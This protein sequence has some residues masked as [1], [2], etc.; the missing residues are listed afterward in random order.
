MKRKL[1][2]ALL[3]CMFLFITAF[4]PATGAYVGTWYQEGE[5]EPSFIFNEDGTCTL[6]GGLEGEWR[7]VNRKYLTI[8]AEDGETYAY[9]IKSLSGSELVLAGE[10][11]KL[12]LTG[13]AVEEKEPEKEEK[14]ES[15]TKAST[16]E[17]KKASLKAALKEAA[18]KAEEE[19]KE[20]EK[21]DSKEETVKEEVKPEE[22]VKEEEPEKEPEAIEEPETEPEIP[23]DPRVRASSTLKEYYAS[24]VLDKDPDTAW[25]EGADGDG[26]GEYLEFTVEDY[27][28]YGIIVLPGYMKNEEVYEENCVPEMLLIQ[29]GREKQ[30]IDI[31]DFEPD[32]DSK[33]PAVYKFEKP[34]YVNVDGKVKVSIVSVIEGTVSEHAGIS[35]L[36]LM[37]DRDEYLAY[38]PHARPDNGTGWIY[39]NSDSVYLNATEISHLSDEDLQLAINEMYARRGYKFRTPEIAAYFESLDWYEGTV[40]SADFDEK[41]F[42]EIEKYNLYLMKKERDKRG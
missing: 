32:F 19:E 27:E 38:T 10:G 42:S 11:E 20:P 2:A 24:N 15:S 6:L 31:S 28:V 18:S 22:T 30:L 3:A 39:K 36:H 40:N 25:F 4:T 5:K 14:T 21:A 23:E 35:E 12:T 26:S 34:L 8:K 9:Q 16:K 1:F 17:E 29:S 33:E 41:V 7:I 13:K 37:T